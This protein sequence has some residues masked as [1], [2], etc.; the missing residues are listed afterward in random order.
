MRRHEAL[1]CAHEQYARV[2]AVAFVLGHGEGLLQFSEGS[3]L[4]GHDAQGFSRAA[5]RGPTMQGWLDKIGDVGERL[6]CRAQHCYFVAC[7]V[8]YVLHWRATPTILTDVAFTSRISGTG[9]SAVI[10][11]RCGQTVAFS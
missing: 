9:S 4:S 5:G 7:S 6:E 11:T 1:Q 3:R 8:A 2:F 10:H